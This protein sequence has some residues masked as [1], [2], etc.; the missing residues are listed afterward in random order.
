MGGVGHAVVLFLSLGDMARGD[1]RRDGGVS[2]RSV[3]KCWQQ[4]FLLG[5][6]WV[7][8]QLVGLRAWWPSILSPFLAAACQGEMAVWKWIDGRNDRLTCFVVQ[9]K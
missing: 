9:G 4:S 5:P 6:R 3:L 1:S 2:A 8:R 7:G